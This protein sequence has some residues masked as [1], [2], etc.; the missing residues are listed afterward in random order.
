MRDP[1]HARHLLG[2][3]L[4]FL[5]E[6]AAQRVEHAALDGAAQRLRVDDQPAVVRAH[7]PLHPDVTGPAIH[8]DLGDLGDD[9]LA[10]EGVGDAAPGEDVAGADAA[11][12]TDAAS[13]P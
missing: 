10:A 4:H 9:G 3:E 1:V 8:L 6:R 12:A 7:Q 13:Q 11:S 5:V 2:V